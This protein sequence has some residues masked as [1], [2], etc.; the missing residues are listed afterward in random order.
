MSELYEPDLSVIIH[1][2]TSNDGFGVAVI[3]DLI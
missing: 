3:C 2:P 1:V